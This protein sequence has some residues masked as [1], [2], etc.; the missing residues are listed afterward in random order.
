MRK[1]LLATASALL[2]CGVAME[3]QAQVSTTSQTAQ[4]FLRL[5]NEQRKDMNVPADMVAASLAKDS[6]G[7]LPVSPE[8]CASNGSCITPRE[9][10]ESIRT[11]HPDV[12]VGDLSNL[13]RYMRSLVKNENPK[14]GNRIVGRVLVQGTQRTLD[15]GMQRAPFDDEVTWHD[16]NTGEEIFMGHCL[17]VIDLN[18][19]DELVVVAEKCPE[20]VVPVGAHG[21]AARMAL[22]GTSPVPQAS[23]VRCLAFMRVGDTDWTRVTELPNEC[24]WGEF[25][26]A[27]TRVT[28]CSMGVVVAAVGKPVQGQPGGLLL[29]KREGFFKVRLPPEFAKEGSGYGFWVCHEEHELMSGHQHP[30]IRHYFGQLTTPDDFVL[31]VDGVKRAR[32]P[33]PRVAS[34]SV[35][36]S[37]E[38]TTP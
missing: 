13:P 28:N 26:L 19:I 16:P 20:A 24:A 38:T 11:K 9:I 32:F 4:P 27:D 36:F 34:R 14:P 21:H 17:N 22:F 3:A 12:Q 1:L 7:N 29:H 15:W 31:E 10:Y 2:F 8:Q 25:K 33:S 23:I 35:A 18:I 6:A 37:F 30:E 5:N